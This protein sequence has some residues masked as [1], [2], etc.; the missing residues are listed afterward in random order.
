LYQYKQ[1]TQVDE[2]LASLEKVL[3]QLDS[4]E[5]KVNSSNENAVVDLL[6]SRVVDEYATKESRPNYITNLVRLYPNT[7]IGSSIDRVLRF[8]V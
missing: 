2:G 3:D 8:V 6:K 1:P 7:T 4:L 5:G